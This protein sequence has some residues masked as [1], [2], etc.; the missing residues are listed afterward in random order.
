MVFQTR[1]FQTRLLFDFQAKRLLEL[2]HQKINKHKRPYHTGAADVTEKGEKKITPLT[3][4]EIKVDNKKQT[5]NQ[6]KVTILRPCYNSDPFSR[7]LLHSKI[8]P[9]FQEKSQ[10]TCHTRTDVQAISECS[11]H[12]VG[13]KIFSKTTAKQFT[14]TSPIMNE[15]SVGLTPVGKQRRR[16]NCEYESFLKSKLRLFRANSD[17]FGHKSQA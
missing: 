7:D 13:E 3:K 6:I 8:F 15:V 14:F 1:H 12:S 5:G 11:T 2:I 17:T 10:R 4:W 9:G 16:N